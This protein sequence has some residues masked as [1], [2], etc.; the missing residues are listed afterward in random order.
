MVPAS[1]GEVSSVWWTAPVVAAPVAGVVALVTALITA[2][3]TI[4]IAERKMRRDFRL[5]FA[6]EGVAHQLMMDAEWPLRSFGVIKSHL[7]GFDDEEL[8]RILVRAGAIRF[9]S[10]SGKELWGLL[11]RN[12]ERLG[13][14]TVGEEPGRRRGKVQ[15]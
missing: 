6:A 15:G 7:G 1:G 13:D 4:G 11:E 14:L 2:L 9:T 12:R 3:V 10:E 5:E 8:R